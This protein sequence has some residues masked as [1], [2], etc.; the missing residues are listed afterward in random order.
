MGSHYIPVGK[1]KIDKYILDIACPAAGYDT[2]PPDPAIY[3]PANKYYDPD[4]PLPYI[5]DE[6]LPAVNP[7][8]GEIILICTTDWHA[9][10]NVQ[11]NTSTGQVKYSIYGVNDSL[12][13][14]QNVNSGVVFFYQF[15]SVGGTDLGNGK[16]AYKVIITAVTGALTI[17][18]TLKKT[19]YDNFGWPILEAH[20]KC[21]SLTTL[22]DAF[23]DEGYIQYIKFYG[24]HDNL[25]SLVQFTKGTTELKKLELP[26]SL[27]GLTSIN[28]MLLSS[29]CETCIFHATSLPELI[30]ALGAFSSSGI[31]SN[32]L[33][34]IAQLPKCTNIGSMYAYTKNLKGDLLLPECPV[35]NNITGIVSGSYISRLIFQ[36]VMNGTFGNTISIIAGYTPYLEEIVLPEEMLGLQDFIY[37]FSS[38]LSL[39]KLTLPKKIV[40][41][42]TV[43]ALPS[44][45]IGTGSEKK[46]NNIEVITT[47]NEWVLVSGR[48]WTE[49]PPR[50]LKRFD[51]PSLAVA[52]FEINKSSNV[53]LDLEYI[54]IN[55]SAL[56][57]SSGSFVVRYANLSQTELNRIS[58]L[59]PTV[60][61][62]IF[63]VTL[64][65]GYAT[66]DKTIAQAKGWTV[67]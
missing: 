4:K 11:T 33:A 66:F 29:G 15:P 64:N 54:S 43:T 44:I 49:T 25:T 19:L 46:A 52:I 13:Y 3:C 45:F 17:F 2:T 59:L 53:Q 28:Y 27:N 55:F 62:G 38:A 56:A 20:I 50:A 58:N 1:L 42:G 5:P 26:T 51:Q 40:L 12:I 47:C 8:D 57:T 37:T 41:S 36:G 39:K 60:T 6:N 35:G 65:P 23:L 10:I 16:L 67:T 22:T 30:T 32:P 34:H 61:S 63:N 9:A 18:K 24:A 31:K 14:S 7:N 21:P 48:S